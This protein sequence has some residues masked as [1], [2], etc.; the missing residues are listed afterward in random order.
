M[1]A[2]VLLLTVGVSAPLLAGFAL[3]WGIGSGLGPALEPLL[4]GR[5]FGRARYASVYGAMDGVDTI[6]SIPGP[7]LGGL[8]FDQTG[9]YTAVLVLYGLTFV[10]GAAGF[11]W[12]A[13]I[14]GRRGAAGPIAVA[15]PSTAAAR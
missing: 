5:V 10:A 4:V 14:V 7:W 15:A 3:L 13:R 1:A 12:L 11:V 9:T 8:L 2:A 6:V